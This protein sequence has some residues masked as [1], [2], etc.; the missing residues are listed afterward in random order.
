ML[1]YFKFEKEI[2]ETK[3]IVAFRT[4][5]GVRVDISKKFLKKDK[6]NNTW[7]FCKN[8]VNIRT[9]VM[10]LTRTHITMGE[11]YIAQCPDKTFA[12]EVDTQPIYPV[13]DLVSYRE[14]NKYRGTNNAEESYR[15]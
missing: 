11:V 4:F 9:G 8:V 13:V 6:L 2:Q 1:Q 12:C 5:D 15:S 3:T 14:L 7:A 10:V